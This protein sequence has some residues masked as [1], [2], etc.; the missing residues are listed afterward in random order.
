MNKNIKIVKI[1]DDYKLVINAGYEDGICEN[2]KYLVYEVSD[3]EI[4][5]PDTKKSLGFLE[6]VKGT[7]KVTHVQEKMS[8]IES[9]VYENSSTKTIRKN[10]WMGAIGDY[11]ETTDSKKTQCPFKDVKLNDFAKQ[12]N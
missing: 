2:Q 10:P 5:D 7:G 6:L 4:F 8:T 3:E 12:V 1:I 9:C 11:V